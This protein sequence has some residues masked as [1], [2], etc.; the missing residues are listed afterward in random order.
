MVSGISVRFRGTRICSLLQHLRSLNARHPTAFTALTVEV[1]TASIASIIP[2]RKRRLAIIGTFSREILGEKWRRS[3]AHLVLGCLSRETLYT[4]SY[5]RNV[6]DSD[7]LVAIYRTTLNLV[8]II[9]P[10][11][12]NPVSCAH[13]FALPPPRETIA[14]L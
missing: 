10:R 13:I 2:E 11:A 4:S 7:V 9:S 5:A 14:G 8:I 12:L 3:V 1:E 6:R